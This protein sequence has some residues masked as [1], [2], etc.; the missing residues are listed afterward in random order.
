[1][2]IKITYNYAKIT[3]IPKPVQ[4]AAEN[5]N[6]L[7]TSIGSSNHQRLDRTVDFKCLKVCS[8]QGHNSREKSKFE[9]RVIIDLGFARRVLPGINSCRKVFPVF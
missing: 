5:L 4:E 3:F 1:M 7:S 6:G 8:K 2:D 9:R